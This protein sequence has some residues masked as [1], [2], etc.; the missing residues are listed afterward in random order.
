M[1]FAE[2]RTTSV[3]PLGLTE[4]GEPGN[5]APVM[6]A[7]VPPVAVQL[8]VALCPRHIGEGEAVNVVT[9]GVAPTVTVTSL[10]TVPHAALTVR[11]KTVVWNGVKSR[12]PEVGTLKTS[13]E[14]WSVM[15]A[16]VPF[17]AHDSWL[18]PPAYIVLGDAEK[19]LIG[20]H[21]GGGV[22][23]GDGI[24]VGVGVGVGIGVPQSLT[25]TV[26]VADP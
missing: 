12:L 16:P 2:G 21:A 26:A 10:V 25:C 24:G 15:V 17:E 11:R 5:P 22:G 6:I 7:L 13:P 8:R 9:L 23:V 4:T 18:L 14:A 3:P 1:V 20:L 19:E